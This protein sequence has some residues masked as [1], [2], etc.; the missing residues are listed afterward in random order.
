MRKAGFLKLLGPT[1]GTEGGRPDVPKGAEKGP[2]A[3]E[4]ARAINALKSK[5]QWTK[6][7]MRPSESLM[8]IRNQRCIATECNS[9]R[10]TA[11]GC[12]C[13]SL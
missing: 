13:P 1:K 6:G 8:A 2:T 12:V 11:D 9:L 7:L 10:K 4:I 5:I 3:G